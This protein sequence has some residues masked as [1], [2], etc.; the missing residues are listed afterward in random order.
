MKN[1]EFVARIGL[2]PDWGLDGVDDPDCE[3]VVQDLICAGCGFFGNLVQARWFSVD[4]LEF[5]RE[6][7]DGPPVIAEDILV[8]QNCGSSTFFVTRRTEPVEGKAGVEQ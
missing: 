7:D 6:T 1:H 5:L 3:G 4:S 2:D 8:C